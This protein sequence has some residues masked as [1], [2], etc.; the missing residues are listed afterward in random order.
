MAP[1]GNALLCVYL[2]LLIA[3]VGAS[4]PLRQEGTEIA[5][6]PAGRARS[7]TPARA[8]ARA[9][10]SAAGTRSSRGRNE[11]PER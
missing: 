5:Y 1:L 4:L 10:V 7:C 9:H 2:V 11:T 3:S 6:L 8:G